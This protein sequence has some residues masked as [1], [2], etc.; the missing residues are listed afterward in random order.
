MNMNTVRVIAI[1]GFLIILTPYAYL[2]AEVLISEENSEKNINLL[3]QSLSHVVNIVVGIFL[4]KFAELNCDTKRLK[5]QL[6]TDEKV[7]L[8]RF[9]E[10]KGVTK[11][12]FFLGWAMFTFGFLALLTSISIGAAK[13]LGLL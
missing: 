7:K 4:V 1:L 8:L 5:A 12:A 11:G 2:I 13:N 6:F 3:I 9:K 10:M